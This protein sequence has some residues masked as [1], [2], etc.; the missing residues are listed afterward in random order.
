[1][2]IRVTA[3]IWDHSKAKLGDRLVLLYIADRCNDD[4]AGAY[5]SVAVIAAHCQL[6]ERSV[7]LSLKRLVELGELE[8]EQ[9]AGPHGVNRYRVILPG[10]KDFTPEKSAPLKNLPPTPEKS[11]PPPLK[12]LQGTPEKSAPNTST[13]PPVEPP[14][15]PSTR[16]SPEF[17]RFWAAYPKGHGSKKASFARWKALSPEKRQAAIAAL[18]AFRAGRNWQEGYVKDCEKFLSLEL[19]DNPPEPWTRPMASNGH[20]PPGKRFATELSLDDLMQRAGGSR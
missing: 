4:G 15:E 19:F 10:C 3:A 18:P 14:T 9:G 20:A 16:Y 17:E 12:N 13:E 1:M 2:S 11:A 8:I 7:R 6:S 5:P